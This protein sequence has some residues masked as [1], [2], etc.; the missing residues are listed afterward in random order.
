MKQY[1]YSIH[2]I[3]TFESKIVLGTTLGMPSIKSIPKLFPEQL[4]VVSP[5]SRYLS[6][7]WNN[8]GCILQSIPNLFREQIWVVSPS[9]QHQICSRNKLIISLIT[10]QVFQ[11]HLS[12][13]FE[14]L[15]LAQ[16]YHVLK[17][18]KCTKFS[19]TQPIFIQ[20]LRC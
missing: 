15:L 6:C 19:A 14:A 8:F 5:L 12:S 1:I 9:S 4:W 7:S 3:S 17:S 11:E 16:N 2:I 10:L 20:T 18:S 13:I